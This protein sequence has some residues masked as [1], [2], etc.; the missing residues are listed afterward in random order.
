MYN[1]DFSTLFYFNPLP[2]WVYDMDSLEI[3]EVNQS[4]LDLYGYTKDEFLTLTVKDIMDDEELSRLLMVHKNILSLKGN[5]HFGTFIHYKKDGSIFHAEMNGLRTGFQDREN[6]CMV[7]C[8][9]VT[10]SKNEQFQKDF[11]SS[12]SAIFNEDVNFNL[13]L[14]RLCELIANFGKFSLCEI[15]LPAIHQGSLKLT[16]H[17]EM[18]AAAHE[19]YRHSSNIQEIEFGK[20]LPGNVWKSKESI[21]WENINVNEIF[22]RN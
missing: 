16:A 15:W 20:G 4:T 1:L 21:L 18:D 13:S 5:K 19:F 6:C 2:H 14:E 11:L 10:E 17:A 12:V 9:D 7:M 8:Q 3:L 22:I